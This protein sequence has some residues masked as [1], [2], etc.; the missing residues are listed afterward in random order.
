MMMR[1]ILTAGVLTAA[2][3]AAVVGAVNANALDAR[4]HAS[5]TPLVVDGE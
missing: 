2:L 5:V 1:M 4:P 3:L